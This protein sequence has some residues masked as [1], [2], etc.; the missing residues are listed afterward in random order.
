MEFLKKIKNSILGFLGFGKGKTKVQEVE[1]KIEQK[2][3][4]VEASIQNQI[5]EEIEVKDEQVIET[6]A[7]ETF[8][9]KVEEIKKPKVEPKETVKDI[10]SLS[11]KKSTKKNDQFNKDSKYESFNKQKR[12][13]TPK[14]KNN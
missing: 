6:K 5:T 4:T 14:K 13:S 9:V 1:S 8:K 11:R 10:K 12:S 2:I 3:E 7:E